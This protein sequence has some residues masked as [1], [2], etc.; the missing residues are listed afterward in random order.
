[1]SE[2]SEV[3]TPTP[4]LFDAREPFVVY[5]RSGGQRTCRLKYP[6]DAQW[7]ERSSKIKLRQIDLGRDKS[8]NEL[9]PMEKYDSELFEKLVVSDNRDDFDEYDRSAVID[10]LAHAEVTE[11]S[12]EGEDQVRIVLEVYGKMDGD[13]RKVT[14][15]LR[16]PRRKDLVEY[17]RVSMKIMAVR[18]GKEIRVSPEPA[19]RIF[20]KY[21]A[22][23]E[24]Y[25]PGSPIPC[26]HQDA[27]V[28]E[29]NRLL[30]EA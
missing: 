14:I 27:A 9:D 1:M 29:L 13:R 7:I 23:A 22:R 5:I 17:G 15:W 26:V 3:A 18:K 10:R 28:I 21:F 11:S 30:G 12:I 25:E 8:I 2:V 24:G 19:M 6:T 4:V 16:E 20:E